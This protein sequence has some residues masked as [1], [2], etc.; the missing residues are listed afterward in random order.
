MIYVTAN[1]QLRKITNLSN[2]EVAFLNKGGNTKYA[3]HP[4]GVE[5]KPQPIETFCEQV[6]RRLAVDQIND[7]IH[8]GILTTAD[9]QIP[10]DQIKS[11]LSVIANT[12]EAGL[13]LDEIDQDLK[14][15][16]DLL[17]EETKFRNVH[18]NEPLP[19][20]PYELVEAQEKV[21]SARKQLTASNA[22]DLLQLVREALALVIAVESCTRV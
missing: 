9:R 10:R 2:T 8:D 22:A 15:C 19:V 21:E 6:Q 16:A 4:W 17:R 7:F 1:K 13:K 18:S 11:L 12:S 20:T 3:T 5:Y 14:K